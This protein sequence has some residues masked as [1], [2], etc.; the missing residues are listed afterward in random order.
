[1]QEMLDAEV[2]KVCGR[3]AAKGS[4]AWNFMLSKLNEYK[5]SLKVED[6][7]EESL[8]ENNYIQEL[9]KRDT[10]LNDNL[11][12]ITKLRAKIEDAIAFY[13]RL[14]EDVKKLD[15]NIERELEQKKR[16]LA[17]TDGLTEE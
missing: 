1:M 9:Q 5:D 7:E 3:P 10:I 14:H 12:N 4:D 16:I 13:N 6:D 15:A 17:Q 2:C 11:S 8:Y